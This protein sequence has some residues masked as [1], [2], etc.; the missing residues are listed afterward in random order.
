MQNG[1]H[2]QSNTSISETERPRAFNFDSMSRFCG[3]WISE[4]VL[5]NTPCDCIHHFGGDL[6]QMAA[7]SKVVRLS[8]KLTDTEP[9]ISTLCLGSVGCRLEE[10]VLCSICQYQVSTILTFM[11]VILQNGSHFHE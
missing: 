2:S 7:I 9:S 4:K 3:A 6:K 10:K 11:A 1:G 8:E 5:P